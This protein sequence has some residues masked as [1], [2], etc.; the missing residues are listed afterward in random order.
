[1]GRRLV[2]DCETDGYLEQT[3]KVHCLAIR[4]V[5]SNEVF[6][7][8][9]HRQTKSY[10]CIEEGLHMLHEADLC[11]AHNGIDF[12]EQAL[13]KV[14]PD[15]SRKGDY[16]DTMTISRAVFTNI[17]DHDFKQFRRNKF[18]GH[19]LLKPHSIEAWGV[20][21]GD[22][23]GEYNDGF[24]HWSPVMHDYC[25]QDTSPARGLFNLLTK[26]EEDRC[27]H[28]LRP[29][30]ILGWKMKNRG[31]KFPAKKIAPMVVETE[32]GVA[33]Y[34]QAQKRNG[35]MFDGQAGAELYAKLTAKRQPI[36]EQ[37]KARFGFW[38]VAEGKTRTVKRNVRYRREHLPEDVRETFHVDTQWQKIKRI[39]FKPSSREHI[40]RVFQ[41][42][43]GWKPQEFTDSGE[44]KVD[45]DIIG[46]L[47]YPEAPLVCE[48]LLLS[49]RIA[50]LAEGKQAWMKLVTKEGFIHGSVNQSGTATHR[51]SHSNPNMTQAPKVCTVKGCNAA[52][53]EK[54]SPGHSPF[55][56]QCRSLFIVPE[57]WKLVGADASGLELRGLSH[58]MHRWDG[59]AYM[60]IVLNGDIHTVNWNA[61]KPFLA[62]RDMAKTFIYAWIYGA[63]DWKLGHTCRPHAAEEEKNEIGRKLR[64]LFLKNLPALEQLVDLVQERV[65][66]NKPFI[67]PTG[68]EVW[69]KK[70][71][72]A[73]NYLIQSLGAIICKRWLFHIERKAKE[74]GL[75]NGWS[76]DYAPCVWAHDE[77]QV[78][79][80]DRDGMP[81]EFG[82]MLVSQL[83]I[84]R[85]ELKLHCPLAGEYKIGNN[86]AETH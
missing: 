1:M 64:A 41:S 20:R 32:L 9:D 33:W 44:V 29:S 71:H 13:A 6:S 14:Y 57:G 85:D 50:A 73:L 30:C 43:Y 45:D 18:P 27:P 68:H 65:D 7:F 8:V 25:I 22:Y 37:M 12:D 4:D 42:E 69:P 19:L 51:A 15:F 3:T 23:K 46:A 82:K 75:R 55:G 28:C 54:P 84:V 61:G 16:F 62:T 80:R 81:E 2:Y 47:P 72:S 31:K 21:L 36:E 10:P 38:Y 58:F 70:K 5:D 48:Y 86:W 78:A 52:E 53:C 24:D 60:D 83:P 39:D 74:L 79:V 66:S 11:V 26:P 35:F 77:V 59:G 67:L 49:K 40:A 63:G 34:L 76:G 17:K 56:L